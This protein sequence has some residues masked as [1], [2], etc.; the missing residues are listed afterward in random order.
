LSIS[1]AEKLRYWKDEETA[2]ATV[3]QTRTERVNQ[4]LKAQMYKKCLQCTKLAETIMQKLLY[5]RN[6]PGK[7]KDKTDRYQ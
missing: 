4:K 7:A 3:M 2:L 6:Y 5:Q 1:C